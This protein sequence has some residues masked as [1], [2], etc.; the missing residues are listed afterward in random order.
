MADKALLSEPEEIALLKDIAEALN[1]ANDL[2]SAMAAILPRLGQVLGL[3]TAWAFRFDPQRA[4][5]V[6]VGASGLPPALSHNNAA[7]LKSSWCECQERLATGRLDTAVNIVR[8]SRLRDAEGE[9]QGLQFHASIPIKMNGRPLGILNVASIGAQVFTRPALDLLRAIG[10]HV[11][12]TLDRAALLSD[13]RRHNERLEALAAI[14]RDLTGVMDEDALF[15][16]SIRLYADRMGFDGVGVIQNGVV[17]HAVDNTASVPEKEYSY[18]DQDS[19]RLPPAERLILADDA[20]SAIAAPVARYPYAIRVE[21]RTAHAFS[22]VDEEILAAFTWYLAALL[23]QIAL[24]RQAL[25][26]A[27]WKERRQLAAD[28]HDSVSQHLFS[29]QLLARTIRQH[30]AGEGVNVSEIGPL[31]ERLETV[32]RHSQSEMRGL[33]EALRPESAPLAYELRHRLLRLKDILGDRL[34]W[35]IPDLPA[36][37]P[38]RLTDGVLRIVDEALQNSLK[39]AQGADLH[40]SFQSR[41]ASYV[42]K[43]S[44]SGPGFDPASVRAGYGLAT[45]QERAAAVGLDWRLDSQS[46]QGTR[47]TV[48]I[49]HAV[50]QH[51]RGNHRGPDPR[52]AD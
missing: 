46:G 41:E 42:L 5:F 18:R 6:E 48:I 43:V 2:S 17:V 21:S 1:E 49:P 22:R 27:R 35:D 50:D 31:G 25:E 33:I 44:D 3:T 34:T 15:R 20:C 45:M 38:P 24:H 36:I 13:M 4:T 26:T 37:F 10:Y 52:R 14:A 16:R 23:E 9:K 12:V 28:L 19:M 47:V 29:A 7:P 39:H 11:A 8:C 40:V 32:L 51:E 30:A